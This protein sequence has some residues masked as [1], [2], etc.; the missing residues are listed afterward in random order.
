Q[1]EEP[2]PRIEWDAD[3]SAA[4]YDLITQMEV[5][6]N[7]LLLFGKQGDENTSGESKI[8]VYKRIGSK[9]FPAMYATSPNALGKRVKGKADSLVTTY[10]KHAKKL[11]VT[12]G[13]LR[14]DED[15]SGDVHEFLEC[16]IS[17]EGPDH[18]TTVKS[19]NLWDETKEEF[20]FFPHLH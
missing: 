13:G 10:K 12:G 4:T 2:F 20:E 14:K 15:D 19:K 3:K 6:E 11:Q 7:R 8:A 18:D 9:I 1:A 5:K 17:S 16:Y